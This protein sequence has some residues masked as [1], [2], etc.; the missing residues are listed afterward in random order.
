MDRMR[1]KSAEGS[2]WVL[3]GEQ[4]YYLSDLRPLDAYYAAR[5][6]QCPLVS[7]NRS[8]CVSAIPCPMFSRVLD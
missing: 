2:Y 1:L 7:L 8:P 3:F 6:C 4:D 5:L